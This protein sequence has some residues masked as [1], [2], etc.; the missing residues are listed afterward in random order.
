MEI[1]KNKMK[2]PKKRSECP[3]ER[4]CPW[5]SCKYHMC[6]DI[7]YAYGKEKI[8]FYFKENEDWKKKDTC[9][10]D[11]IKPGEIMTYKEIGSYFGLSKEAIRQII[12]KALEKIKE[13]TEMIDDL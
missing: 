12:N 7:K 13:N 5:V 9:L 6:F 3:I 2:S 8:C 1:G 4:P 11:I 10:F